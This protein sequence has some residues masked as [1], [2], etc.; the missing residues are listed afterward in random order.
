MDILALL[1]SG[2]NFILYCSMSQQFRSTFQDL[3]WPK[4]F[5]QCNKP[6]SHINVNNN[7][8]SNKTEATN[9]T[10]V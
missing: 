4:Y 1:N 7:R 5:D 6:K 2:I 8:A 9:D 3:F 10:N